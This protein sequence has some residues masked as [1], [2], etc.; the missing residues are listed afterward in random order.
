MNRKRISIVLALA[1]ISVVMLESRYAAASGGGGGL[2][3]GWYKSGSHPQNYEMAIDTTVKRGG[4]AGAHIKFIAD[5]PEGFGTLMQSFRA[6]DYRG[7]RLRMSAWVKTEGVESAHLFVRLDGERMM[8]GF[9]NM[10]NRTITGTTDWRKYDITLDVPAETINVAFGVFV[11]GRGVAWVDD[12]HFETVGGDVATT[13]LL[14]PEMRKAERPYK[15]SAAGTPA[16]PTNLD[17][18]SGADPERK[19]ARVD[20]KIYDEYAGQYQST[21][22]PVV[23]INREGDRLLQQLP[24]GVKNEWLPLS[25]TEFF[26]PNNPQGSAIFVKNAQGQVTHY[27]RRRNGRDTIIKKIN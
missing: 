14:T 11:T 27:I 6:D 5:K 12:F 8:L 13:D 18:E 15:T 25:T 24:G 7:K 22:G 21:D 1:L 16:R 17:F 26:S 4:T 2:P 19:V 3:A 23:T 9:D 10:D 20:P